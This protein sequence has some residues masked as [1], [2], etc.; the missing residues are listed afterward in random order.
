MIRGLAVRIKSEYERQHVIYITEGRKSCKNWKKA[1]KDRIL[2]NPEES[3]VFDD[4]DNDTANFM[5]NWLVQKSNKH[6]VITYE[7]FVSKYTRPI[8]NLYL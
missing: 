7:E 2:I 4:N 6:P 3:I 5:Y 8:I 1:Q